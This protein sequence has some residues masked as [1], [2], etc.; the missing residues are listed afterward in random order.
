MTPNY[1]KHDTCV[2]VD[3]FVENRLLTSA[4]PSKDAVSNKMHIQTAKKILFKINK[5]EMHKNT[6]KKI[7]QKFFR[8][9]LCITVHSPQ[10]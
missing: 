4:H 6:A 5:L 1:T 8:I 7:F 2:I 9:I 3:N 10:I